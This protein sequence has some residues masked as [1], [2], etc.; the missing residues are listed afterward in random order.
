MNGELGTLAQIQANSNG[1]RGQ[2]QATQTQTALVAQLVGQVQKQ[3]QLNL[4]A[5]MQEKVELKR[6]KAMG[7]QGSSVRDRL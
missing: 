6:F 5:I 1:A 4:A 7:Y 2:L 3:R